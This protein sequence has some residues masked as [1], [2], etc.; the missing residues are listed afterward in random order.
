MSK[1]KCCREG[2]K[3]EVGIQRPEIEAKTKASVNRLVVEEHG[4]Y[5]SL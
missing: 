1:L 3:S 5:I 4:F 2:S